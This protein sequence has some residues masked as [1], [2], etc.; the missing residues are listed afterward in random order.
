MRIGDTMTN[1]SVSIDARE[2]Q[3]APL[4]A[5][6]PRLVKLAR[7]RMDARSLP[8]HV[9]VVGVAIDG[10]DRDYI[11]R[12]LGMKLAK[13]VAA[14][15]RILSLGTWCRRRSRAVIRDSDAIRPAALTTNPWRSYSALPY[16]SGTEAVEP[17]ASRAPDRVTAQALPALWM[18]SGAVAR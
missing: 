17:H 8:A 6:V 10:E 5:S 16:G 15:E 9:R 4:A 13:V 1:D 11:F 14:V 7:D 2:H 3:R 12:T 18:S